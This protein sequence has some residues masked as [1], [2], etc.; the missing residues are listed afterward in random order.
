[1]Q[2][3]QVAE[4]LVSRGF[5]FQRVYGP[6]GKVAVPYPSTMRD[7]IEFVKKYSEQARPIQSGEY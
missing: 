5:K 1:M 7:A 4:F 3:W 2:A 6:D